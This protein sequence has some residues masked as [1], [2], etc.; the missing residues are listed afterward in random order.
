MTDFLPANRGYV[1]IKKE[2]TYGTDPT[3]AIT[4]ARRV[5]NWEMQ[6]K[7]I[8]TKQ[9]AMS[10]Y[11]N[12]SRNIRTGKEITFSGETPL[13]IFDVP[14]TDEGSRAIEDPFLEM[15]GFS[16]AGGWD[17]G[18]PDTITHTCKSQGHNSVSIEEYFFNQA[19]TDG[20]AWQLLGCR[21]DF[22]VDFTPGEVTMLKFTGEG[23]AGDKIDAAHTPDA[24]LT[25]ASSC[26]IVGDTWVVTFTQVEGSSAY[27]GLVRE[28]SLTGNMNLQ[29]QPGLSGTV[30]PARIRLNP[31]DG[32]GLSLLVEQMDDADWDPETMLADCDGSQGMATVTL[33]ST[34]T[35]TMTVSLTMSLESVDIVPD[36]EGVRMW[37]LNHAGSYPVDSDGG[38][39]KPADNLAFIYGNDSTS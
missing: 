26:D 5:F 37:R 34:N 21:A 15:C 36:Q 11:R 24:S 17:T 31:Q 9:G 39:L 4:D 20:I 35:N 38:G 28:G 19:Q 13:T 8:T 2:S 25:Y 23:K 7:D 32:V 3:H 1:L 22:S 12:G 16:S 27:T 6:A 14:E 10:P 30:G 29:R 18:F 33:V